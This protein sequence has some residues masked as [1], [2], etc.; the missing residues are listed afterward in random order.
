MVT[1]AGA[2]VEQLLLKQTV[3]VTWVVPPPFRKVVKVFWAP[4]NDAGLAAPVAVHVMAVK[5]SANDVEQS[6]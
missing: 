3:A 5:A 1:T 2:E 4:V 6:T